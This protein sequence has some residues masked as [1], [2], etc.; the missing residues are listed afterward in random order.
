MPPDPDGKRHA[1]PRLQSDDD[2]ADYLMQARQ[3]AADNSDKV[4]VHFIDMAL[5]E[6]A[7]RS[8]RKPL[9]GH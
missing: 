4:L 7:H 9:D 8:V 6:L 2:I 1:A 5:Y 3:L